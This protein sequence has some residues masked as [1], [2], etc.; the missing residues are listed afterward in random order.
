MCTSCDSSFELQVMENTNEIKS[1][2]SS[3]AK[4]GRKEGRK[5]GKKEARKQGRKEGLTMDRAGLKPFTKEVIGLHPTQ[6][7]I[8]DQIPL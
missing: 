4:E 2:I 8:Y 5:E 1:Q 6:L 3:I 7:V